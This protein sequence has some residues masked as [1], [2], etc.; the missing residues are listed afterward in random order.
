MIRIG[1]QRNKDRS[2]YPVSEAI[3]SNLLLLPV[4]KIEN[5]MKLRKQNPRKKKEMESKIIKDPKTGCW[6]WT[7]SKDKDGYPTIQMPNPNRGKFRATRIAY[8]IYKGIK[9]GKLLVCHH[10]D[11]PPCINPDHLF[12]GTAKDNAQDCKNKGRHNPVRGEDR[13]QS[14]LTEKQVLE[15][16]NITS[17][18]PKP[19][20]DEEIGEK[21][22]IHP[23]YVSLI[24]TR[25]RWKHI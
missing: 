21:Y 23:G 13:P 17:K 14:K 11:N 24:N 19:M 3:Y 7:G 4:A 25:K 20:T 10:C 18:F 8:E 16:R 1:N 12:L 15:I 6:N 22:N 2:V 9:P 5:N